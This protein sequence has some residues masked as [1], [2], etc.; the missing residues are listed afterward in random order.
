MA[1]NPLAIIVLPLHAGGTGFWDEVLAI[2]GT[3]AF[4]VILIHMFFFDGRQDE[5][6][7]P[8]NRTSDYEDKNR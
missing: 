5:P 7:Q 6:F 1:L 3:I 2:I 8:K 4:I